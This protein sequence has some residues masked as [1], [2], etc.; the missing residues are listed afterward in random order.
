M[1]GVDTSDSRFPHH[2]GGV[3]QVEHSARWGAVPEPLLE[4]NRLDL[5]SRAVAAWLAIKPSGWQISIAALRRRLG[6]LIHASDGQP[7][8]YRNLGKDRWQRIA[9]E[10]EAAGYLQ[11]DRRNGAAGQ[12]IWHIVFNPVPPRG[13]S[14]GT[15]A[16]FPGDGSS[17]TGLAGSGSTVA[18]KPGHKERPRKTHTNETTTTS[19]T[20]SPPSCVVDSTAQAN[21]I[22]TAVVV[23]KWAEPHKEILFRVLARAQLNSQDAQQIADEFAGVLEAASRG[24]HPEIRNKRGW[25][26]KLVA[27]QKNDDFVFEFGR[28]VEAR[29]QRLPVSAEPLA[30]ANRHVVDAQIKDMRETLKHARRSV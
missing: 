3:L 7:L 4:D 29:R 12:W 11:R 1:T 13:P 2:S 21:P 25:L 14:P 9:G 18:G 23:D 28:A 26:T 19:T 10:L 30:R 24:N 6:R 20:S 5:D 15:I 27:G 16:G 17:A 22:T 8:E